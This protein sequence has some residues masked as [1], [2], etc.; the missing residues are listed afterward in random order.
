MKVK[1]DHA[2]YKI[3]ALVAHLKHNLIKQ[4]LYYITVYL[5]LNSTIS[6]KPQLSSRQT[7]NF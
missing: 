5:Q 6:I 1:L 3:V 2:Y 4:I 7:I